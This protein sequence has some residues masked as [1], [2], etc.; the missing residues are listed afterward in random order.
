VSTGNSN[1]GLQRGLTLTELAIAMAVAGIFLAAAYGI[2]LTQQKTY[3]VQDQVA[4]VQ[5]HARVTMN[6]LARDLRMAGHGIPTEAA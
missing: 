2:F 6:M 3:A 5:Q 1:L 4:E